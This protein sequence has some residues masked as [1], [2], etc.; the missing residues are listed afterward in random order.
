MVWA[1]FSAHGYIVIDEE[2]MMQVLED[3]GGEIKEIKGSLESSHHN[4][5]EHVSSVVYV[6][7]L[8]SSAT[9]R[10]SSMSL[11]EFSER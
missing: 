11:I 6:R 2:I 8:N 5:K 1:A 3:P 9:G 10:K 7:W 4:V